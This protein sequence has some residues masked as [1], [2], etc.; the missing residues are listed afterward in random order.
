MNRCGYTKEHFETADGDPQARSPS[1]GQLPVGS[2]RL[3]IQPVDASE[4]PLEAGRSRVAR[5]G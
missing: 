5:G 1:F 4:Q 3:R 2:Y